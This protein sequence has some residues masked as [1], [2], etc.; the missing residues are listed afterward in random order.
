MLVCMLCV[1]EGHA[2]QARISKSLLPRFQPN[3]PGANQTCSL[4]QKQAIDVFDPVC[5][6]LP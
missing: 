3:C 5:L 4:S 6:A 2:A 1:L